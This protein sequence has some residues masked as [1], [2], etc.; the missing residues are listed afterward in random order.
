MKPKPYK[1]GSIEFEDINAVLIIAT[2]FLVIAII[3]IVCFFDNIYF[4]EMPFFT[5]PVIAGL[6]LAHYRLKTDYKILYLKIVIAL[7]ISAVPFIFGSI[8]KAHEGFFTNWPFLFIAIFSFFSAIYHERSV[9]I[10]ITEGTSLLH[11]LSFIYG[12]MANEFI[13]E[14][15][16]LQIILALVGAPFCLL[17]LYCAFSNKKLTPF[18]R[19]WLSRWSSAIVFILSVQYILGIYKFESFSSI[20]FIDVL[21]NIFQYLL[22]G[23]SLV[24]LTQNARMILG[25]FSDRNDE[26]YIQKLNKFHIWRFSSKQVNS[27]DSLFITLILVL[28]YTA[29]YFLALIP[30]FTAI[31]L[32]L[33]LAPY[34][35]A[36]RPLLKK[37]S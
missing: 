24:Y 16:S 15:V 19:L 18:V 13:H 12:L 1:F 35:I 2:S 28:F 5:L 9:T 33:S 10:K 11:T 36:L 14:R 22:L 32:S 25:Y 29:N 7:C 30:Y 26:D 8:Q 3:Y 23:I 37:K 6:L 31:M 21:I 17:S 4:S 34:I 27:K 20:D